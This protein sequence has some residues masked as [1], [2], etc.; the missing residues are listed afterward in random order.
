V[1]GKPGQNGR[2]WPRGR[3]SL[4]RT[5]SVIFVLCASL[6]ACDPTWAIIAENRSTM[7]LYVKSRGQLRSGESFTEV[8]ALPPGA[9]V[10]LGEM[11]VGQVRTLDGIDILRPDCSLVQ[12][13]S[14]DWQRFSEGG[15]ITVTS[16]PVATVEPG[17]NPT[18][19][20]PPTRVHACA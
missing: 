11:G 6:A 4:A 1:T 15:L 16:G 8:D 20:A 2:R 7:S 19:G 14:I 5:V 12:S 18:G 17:G 13:V 3:G 9:R 10:Q